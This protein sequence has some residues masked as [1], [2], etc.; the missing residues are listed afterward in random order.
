MKSSLRLLLLCVALAFVGGDVAAAKE[1]FTLGTVREKVKRDYARV[2]HMTIDS[3][4]QQLAGRK[5]VVLFDVREDDE[6]AVSRIAG[7]LQVDPG[8]WRS[9]FMRKFSGSVR[10]KTVVFYCSVG[11][12]SSKLA[13]RVQEELKAQGALAVYNLDGGVFAWHNE[14]RPLVNGGGKTPFVH[15]YDSHWGKLLNRRDFVRTA[16]G[17]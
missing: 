7:A 2:T 14:D 10:G 13:E 5:D 3:L 6:F 8:I 9:T 17:S 11:V 16:P 4:A 12:R 1:P 15:P